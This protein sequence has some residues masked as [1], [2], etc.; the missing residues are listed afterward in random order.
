MAAAF[1]KM[2]IHVFVSFY[3][4]VFLKMLY[5]HNKSLAFAKR[6]AAQCEFLKPGCRLLN[7][8]GCRG[9]LKSVKKTN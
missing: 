6:L 1:H 4:L 9:S 5:S 3:T 7:Q 2:K 8:K